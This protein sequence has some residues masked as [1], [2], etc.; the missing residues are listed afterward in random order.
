MDLKKRPSTKT[1]FSKNVTRVQLFFFLSSAE[2]SSRVKL[3][4]MLIRSN[5]TQLRNLYTFFPFHTN[6]LLNR[7][8]FKSLKCIR[9]AL[10]CLFVTE[11]DQAS[12]RTWSKNNLFFWNEELQTSEWPIFS[13]LKSADGQIEFWFNTQFRADHYPNLKLTR[14]PIWP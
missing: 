5:A 10:D 7:Y 1:G 13:S 8:F 2:I 3:L 6:P 9:I 4:I 11:Y 14:I 12:R